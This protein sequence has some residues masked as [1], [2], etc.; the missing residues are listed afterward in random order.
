[1][2]KI[3]KKT[4]AF[5]TWI[6]IFIGFAAIYFLFMN[7]FWRELIFDNSKTGGRYGE[8]YPS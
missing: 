2:K 8:V 1:M 4:R 5:P 7:S 3:D 6:F